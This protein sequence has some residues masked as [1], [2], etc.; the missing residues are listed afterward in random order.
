MHDHEHYMRQAIAL[1]ANVPD[2]PFGAV[3]VDGNNGKVLS[4]GWKKTPLNPMWHGE[5]D[6]MNRFAASG[7]SV[8]VKRLVLYTTAEPC[9][10]CQAAALWS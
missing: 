1:A 6:G 10:I 5:I 3:I 9:R 7:I 4:E 8:E 2:L